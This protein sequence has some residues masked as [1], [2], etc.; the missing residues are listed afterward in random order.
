MKQRCLTPTWNDSTMMGCRSTRS[1]GKCGKR[2][3]KGFTKKL[4]WSCHV[5]QADLKLLASSNSLTSA[6]QNTGMTDRW[7]FAMLPKMV[8]NSVSQTAGITGLSH[9]VQSCDLHIARSFWALTSVPTNCSCSQHSL[10]HYS[11]KRPPVELP[12]PAFSAENTSQKV[13]NWNSCKSLAV[14]DTGMPVAQGRKGNWLPRHKWSAPLA[15]SAEPVGQGLTLLPR[16]ECSGAISAHCNLYLPGSSEPPTSAS[17][18]AGTTD[19]CHHTQPIFVFSVE[20]GFCNVAQAG[21]K[22]LGSSDSPILASRS[23]GMTGVSCYAWPKQ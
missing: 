10:I 6:S 21:L 15:G 17:Q 1:T 5:P 2:V 23:A 19:A 4:A 12:G 22:L 7:S 18:V 13:C 3:C 8:L 16:L 14:Q 20:T 11:G 9:G